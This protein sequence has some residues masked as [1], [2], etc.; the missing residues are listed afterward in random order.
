MKE[1][2][3]MKEKCVQALK[4][5]DAFVDGN[6][7]ELLEEMRNELNVP[8]C[9]EARIVSNCGVVHGCFRQTDEEEWIRVIYNNGKWIPVNFYLKL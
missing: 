5:I 3:K 1:L 4:D 7:E 8:L 6:Y 2:D 9:W